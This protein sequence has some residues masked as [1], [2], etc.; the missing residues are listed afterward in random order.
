MIQALQAISG[1]GD[2]KGIKVATT[3]T[4]NPNGYGPNI[5]EAWVVDDDERTA[6]NVKDMAKA[7]Q[8]PRRQVSQA[9]LEATAKNRGMTVDQVK[10]ALGLK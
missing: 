5:Q 2:R 10:Q 8:A 4:P 1:K 9:E 3:S 6:T 7:T